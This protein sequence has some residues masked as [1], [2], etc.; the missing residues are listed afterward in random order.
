[1]KLFKINGLLFVSG[2]FNDVSINIEDNEWQLVELLN[3]SSEMEIG[4]SESM[5]VTTLDY[6]ERITSGSEFDEV[7]TFFSNLWEKPISEILV[8]FK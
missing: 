1:M 3:V 6:F 7:V 5:Y 4:I 2:R 8:L